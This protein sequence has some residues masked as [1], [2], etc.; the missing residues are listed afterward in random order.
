MASTVDLYKG[1]VKLGSGTAAAGSTSI[2]GF[3]NAVGLSYR[4]GTN[5]RRVQILVTQAGTHVG[6]TWTTRVLADNGSGT[7][8]LRDACPFV[9]A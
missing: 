5:K 7:L 2:T 4:A 3:T 8:T 9:G 1:P 6:R